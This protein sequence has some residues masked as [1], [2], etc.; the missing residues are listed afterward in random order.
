MAEKRKLFTIRHGIYDCECVYDDGE[1]YNKYKLYRI[2]TDTN[3]YG[4]PSKHRKLIVKYA[5]FKSILCHM[6]DDALNLDTGSEK[7]FG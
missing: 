3:K 5:D 4:Y 6:R 2:W 1:K 7:L